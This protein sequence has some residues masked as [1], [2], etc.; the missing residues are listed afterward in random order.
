MIINTNINSMFGLN[1]ISSSEN[2]VRTISERLSSGYRINRGADDPSGLAISEGMRA[3]YGG[4]NTAIQNLQDFQCYLEARDR[5]MVEQQNIAHKVRDLAVRAANEAPLTTADRQKL[6]NDASALI[7]TLDNIGRL[8]SLRGYGEDPEV[9][10][11]FGPGELDVVWILDQTGS[12]TAHLTNI[13]N[14]ANDM[15][16]QFDAKK[17]DVRMAAFGFGSNFDIPNHD[18]DG[19]GPDLQ[20]PFGTVNSLDGA[21]SQQFQDTAALFS[22]DVN[23]IKAVMTGGAERGM[24]ATY[25]A[26]QVLTGTA[27]SA[28]AGPLEFREDAQKLFLLITDEDSDDAGSGRAVVSDI[29]KTALRTAIDTR[30]GAGVQIWTAANQQMSG[31]GPTPDQ[32]YL[33][34]SSYSVNLDWDPPGPVNPGTAW[35]DS[36]VNNMLGLGGPYKLYVQYGPD[37]A[38]SLEVR[39]NTVI[40]GTTGI[41]N[42]NLG[43]VAGAQAAIDTCDDAIQFIADE[44][45]YTG[46]WEERVNSMINDYTAQYNNLRAACSTI[47][48][49]DMADHASQMAKQQVILN[50]SQA[51]T[52]QANTL[53]GVVMDLINQ[54]GIGQNNEMI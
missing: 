13:V 10:T 42:V 20:S 31:G 23:A 12:M 54:Q 51:V 8:S 40:S 25:Q 39:F 6:Q 3:R 21:G 26:A 49:A 28:T 37:S 47:K 17:F 29:M 46:A 1:R 48:D 53:P 15:F 5:S 30:F 18:T 33:D 4:I 43:T 34:I 44:Q 38:D 19:N 52:A 2:M 41:A 45:A 50:S 16:S 32:D 14:A 11:L 7:D 36:V 35:V 22:G 9:R 27:P 24:D